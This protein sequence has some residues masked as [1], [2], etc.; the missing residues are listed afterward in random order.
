MQNTVEQIFDKLNISYKSTSGGKELQFNCVCK[1]HAD[2]HAS[3]FINSATGLWHCFGCL[4]S[5]NLKTLVRIV[6]GGEIK[7]ESLVTPKDSLKMKIGSIYKTSVGQILSYENDADFINAF[8]LESENFVPA[9]KSKRA[10]NYL[11]GEKRKLTLKTIRQFKLMYARTGKYENRVIIPYSLNNKIIG[12]NSRFIGECDSSKR[13]RYLINEVRFENYIFNYENAID[14]KYCI[15]V[16]GPFD[17][18]YLVQCGY[19]N[20]VSTLN[21]R[22]SNG[23]IQKLM[24]FKKIIFCFD[25][26]ERTQAGQKAVLKHAKNILE[27]I[28]DMLLYTVPLPTDT[29]ANECE[30]DI[31]G[32]CF[33]KLQR[34]KME[35]EP[36][37]KAHYR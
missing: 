20:V 9:E 26:D 14:N 1:D 15:L 16:E 33:G 22:L 5:G 35:E 30:P 18:M 32:E 36:E 34:L 31:L 17:L 27:Y 4:K 6:S 28:P 19:K 23:H 24:K 11:T 7:W 2:T 29:D 13:Y 8:L 21:T 25:N 37:N 12:M 3:A 10:Y